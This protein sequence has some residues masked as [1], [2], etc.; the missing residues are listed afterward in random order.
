MIRKDSLVGP[1]TSMLE[2]NIGT[3]EK[4]ERVLAFAYALQQS[5][6]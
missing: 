5:S 4:K 1:L 3:R 2:M 6:K